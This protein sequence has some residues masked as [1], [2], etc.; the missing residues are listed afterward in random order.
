M[1]KTQLFKDAIL[2]ARELR[3]LAEKQVR[4]QLMEELSPIIK[5]ALS[6]HLSSLLNEQEGLEVSETEEGLAG[7]EETAGMPVTATSTGVEVAD[8]IKPTSV[9]AVSVPEPEMPMDSVGGLDIPLPGPDGMITISV[10]DLFN[11]PGEVIQAVDGM[12]D[13]EAVVAPEVAA[14]EEPTMDAMPPEGDLPAPV[15]AGGMAPEDELFPMN[16][17]SRHKFLRVLGYIIDQEKSLTEK[18]INEKK[19][20]SIECS[21][22]ALVESGQN[23]V[24]KKLIESSDLSLCKKRATLI[25][26]SLQE[27]MNTALKQNSYNQSNQEKDGETMAT[28]N[29]LKALFEESELAF[30]KLDTDSAMKELE[31]KQKKLNGQDPG[32]EGIGEKSKDG[33][34][35]EEGADEAGKDTNT[36]SALE[37]A[38]ELFQAALSLN[39]NDDEMSVVDGGGSEPP[40]DAPN[41]GPGMDDAAPSDDGDFDIEALLQDFEQQL[42]DHGVDIQGLD[43]DVAGAGAEG[44]EDFDLHFSLDDESGKIVPGGEEPSELGDEPGF[45]GDEP[46]DEMVIAEATKAVK[47][48]KAKLKE[49]YEKAADQDLFLAKTKS[50]NLLMMSEAI[51]DRKDKMA[52]IAALDKGTTIKEVEAIYGRIKAFK[53]Q[54]LQE[55]KLARNGKAAAGTGNS[56]VISES[57]KIETQKNEN[58]SFI[59]RLQELAKVTK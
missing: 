7:A 43:L 3:E 46:S 38:M 15:D 12:G 53:Q 5:N 50:L 11:K 42:Q 52:A 56:N 45:G 37:E 24:Q 4:N 39:E 58:N 40:M 35:S 6:N 33:D 21:L 48:A 34:W 51:T 2:E 32:Q 27:K 41:D 8:E 30:D 9:D 10:D 47:L 18:N 20:T 26:N 57:A 1:K 25:K 54:K 49:A 14:T 31:A 28:N 59:S 17:S 44:G 36:K 55:S 29:T 16:E 23:L 22:I 13:K 19:I